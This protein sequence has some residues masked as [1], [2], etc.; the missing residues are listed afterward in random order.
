MIYSL[1]ISKTDP[2][3]Q[4]TTGKVWTKYDSLADFHENGLTPMF[5]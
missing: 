2:T 3:P 5:D 4:D 1:G